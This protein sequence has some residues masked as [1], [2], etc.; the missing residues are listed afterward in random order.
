MGVYAWQGWV[1]R[2]LSLQADG[3]GSSLAFMFSVF[4]SPRP[5]ASPGGEG[6]GSGPLIFPILTWV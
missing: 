5:T 2:L 1:Y 4:L 6:T 3:M